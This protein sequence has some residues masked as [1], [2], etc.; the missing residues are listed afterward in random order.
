MFCLQYF[1]KHAI[2]LIYISA[3]APDP[4]TSLKVTPSSSSQLKVT[5]TASPG[6][7]NYTVSYRL[8]D[9]YQCGDPTPTQPRMPEEIV[10][11]EPWTLR[12][13]EPNSEYE[14]YVTANNMFGSSNEST[15]TGSTKGGPSMYP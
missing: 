13:L 6:A 10:M 8:L 12:N 1:T 15:K 5:W 11:D 9:L 2:L 14:V 7:D 3:T 4:V